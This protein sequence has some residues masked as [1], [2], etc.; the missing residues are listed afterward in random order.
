MLHGKG[1]IAP[2][3]RGMTQAARNGGG[4]PAASAP[5]F[6]KKFPRNPYANF[7]AR[8]PAVSLCVSMLVPLI[9]AIVSLGIYTTLDVSTDRFTAE[10]SRAAITARAVSAAEDYWR[11][12]SS[13]GTAG[14]NGLAAQGVRQ[15]PK[16]HI[17]L[18]FLLSC[19]A[20]DNNA[21]C[22]SFLTPDNLH[23]IRRVE[24]LVKTV[25]GYNTAC[26]TNPFLGG[27]L[28]AAVPSCAPINSVTQYFFATA[29]QQPPF[30]VFD[31]AGELQLP[32]ADTLSR[33]RLNPQAEWYFNRGFRQTQQMTA[34]RSQVVLGWPL[35]GS[36]GR[37]FT[38][39]QYDRY[40]DAIVL[41]IY[42]RVTEFSH[43]R[44]RVTI[45]GDRV[46]QARVAR[47]I[48][49]EFWRAPVSIIIVVAILFIHCRTFVV[50]CLGAVQILLA[51][52]SGLSI[53][54]LS[55]NGH[56]PMLSLIALF[57]TV[58]FGVDGV[59][60]T[61]DTFVH[62]GIF[63]TSGRRNTLTVAQ[64]IA[65]VQRKALRGIAVAHV[66]AI[67]VFAVATMSPVTE[68]H[69]F[70]LFMVTIL[71]CSLY[72][73]ATF[74][75]AGVLF[76]HF[77][78]SK[79][80]RALQK[81]KE[82]LLENGQRARHP[83]MI[84]L[85][86]SMEEQKELTGAPSYADIAEG[87][88]ERFAQ[89]S[90]TDIFTHTHF[91][92]AAAT[93]EWNAR[94][95]VVTEQRQRKRGVLPPKER[96]DPDDN[97]AA[98]DAFADDNAVPEPPA[99]RGADSPTRDDGEFE[100]VPS[101]GRAVVRVETKTYSPVDEPLQ[102]PAHDD[103]IDIA[104]QSP[105]ARAAGATA[106][107][108]A[109]VYTSIR[110]IPHKNIVHVPAAMCFRSP[111]SVDIAQRIIMA[112]LAKKPETNDEEND[113]TSRPEGFANAADDAEE[114]E[115]LPPDGGPPRPTR[116]PKAED[117]LPLLFLPVEDARDLDASESDAHNSRVDFNRRI[118]EF[119]A[120]WDV[121]AADIEVLP[122]DSPMAEIAPLLAHR[123]V[124]CLAGP[125]YPSDSHIARN[126]VNAGLGRVK[127]GFVAD[128]QELDVTRENKKRQQENTR[129]C[130]SC[131]KRWEDRE[132]APRKYCCG[133][134]GSRENEGRAERDAR[135]LSK[136]VKHEG[137]GRMER[138][139]NNTWATG[140]HRGR[141]ALVAVMVIAIVGG[142]V[143]ISYLKPLTSTVQLLRDNTNENEHR[144]ASA[145][146]ATPDEPCDYCG[147]AY[148]TPEYRFHDLTQIQTCAAQGYGQLLSAYVDRCGVC[149]GSD[150]CVDCRGVP[151]GTYTLDQ[152]GVCL[153]PNSADRDHCR[154]CENPTNIDPACTWC[155]VHRNMSGFAGAAC[156]KQCTPATCPPARGRCNR[157]TG[158][159]ECHKDSLRGWFRTV[160]NGT[161]P[162]T[163]CNAC[164][165]GFFPE[166]QGSALLNLSMPCTQE[167]SRSTAV[168]VACGSCDFTGH[169][170][171]SW[172][173]RGS[174]CQARDRALCNHGTP[175]SS[176]TCACDATHGGPACSGDRTCS[177]RG[178][179]YSALVAPELGCAC[180]GA[181][182]G[183][184]CEYCSCRNG[185]TCTATGAC[186]C[187]AG[188]GGDL[189][190]ACDAGCSRGGTCPQPWR[191]DE[192][193][194]GACLVLFCSAADVALG[195]SCPACIRNVTGWCGAHNPP[196]FTDPDLV[197]RQR[198]CENDPVCMWNL[199]EQLC[200]EKYNRTARQL[201][202]AGCGTCRGYWAGP[203]CA[204][205]T[206]TGASCTPAGS[207]QACDG[208]V[209]A[210]GMPFPVIDNCGTCGGR[211]QCIGC[212]GV[213]NSNKVFDV[214]GVCGGDGACRRGE[215]SPIDVDFVFGVLNP[216]S[217]DAPPELPN[218]GGTHIAT[219]W[220]FANPD[221]ARSLKGICRQ[222]R[223]Q[224]TG[225]NTRVRVRSCVV[226]DYALW[227]TDVTNLNPWLANSSGAAV[228]GFPLTLFSDRVRNQVFYHFLQTTNRMSEVGWRTLDQNSSD[229]K[230]AYIKVGTTA[231]A[232]HG[233]VTSQILFLQDRFDALAESITSVTGVSTVH[234]SP[235]WVSAASIQQSESGLIW[236]TCI[237][238][239]VFVSIINIITCSV[240][241]TVIAMLCVGGTMLVS[242]AFFAAF[243]F[244]LGAVEQSGVSL[245]L[246]ISVE[247][248]IHLLHS[249]LDTVHGSQSHLFAVETTRLQSF[250]GAVMRSGS[251]IVA[252]SA[253]GIVVAL[254]HISSDV[255]PIHR[256]AQI[257]II[258]SLSSLVFSLVFAGALLC[259]IGPLVD[260][261]FITIAVTLLLV[262]AAAWGVVVFGLFMGK[263]R[264]PDGEVAIR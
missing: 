159:C 214:C 111:E 14:F 250:R 179:Y 221:T 85:L 166:V 222:F 149:Y 173:Y 232:E 199:T 151:N 215:Q 66:C 128:T 113:D 157:W 19:A 132:V 56:L 50:A 239:F 238:F 196:H 225:A 74:T 55:R 234:T 8:Y 130:G 6:G 171:C 203:N 88:R 12:I 60:V 115:M 218:Y 33:L 98:D 137:Y 205:C 101:G 11:K 21:S 45:D 192:Y 40:V 200:F 82:T 144:D 139:F 219:A 246:G 143:G 242:I 136:R 76:H 38:Q 247:N 41:R 142:C 133:M 248:A 251:A 81:Q 69:D 123:V 94:F 107:P 182:A 172:G 65:Y 2:D 185:G 226:D 131:F 73:F 150:A 213:I 258:V 135:I 102:G 206:A 9:L 35:I 68:L 18:Q 4:D 124:S 262:W 49:D 255:V 235:R 187:R 168:A 22:S 75:P 243:D 72:F 220:D 103:F 112:R 92:T 108:L 240:G 61:Y 48:E 263:A 259:L 211:N 5:V 164:H 257:T 230:V 184:S 245:V 155:G 202:A 1:A 212:D 54:A 197:V 178:T 181:W 3:Q 52:L 57:V 119:H 109:G 193:D 96:A 17:T 237:G 99:R 254:L 46:L 44:V 160:G 260:Y 87:Q 189:C 121:V 186:E 233:G 208:R 120:A 204:T 175:T 36:D 153:P 224:S 158:E 64:R 180:F 140:V 129:F 177:N 231:I 217:T 26:W 201:P 194:W 93:A 249:Y 7:L 31:G 83:Q 58:L 152:C 188:W 125:S 154:L 252:S 16:Y 67:I 114:I 20:A 62:S 163:S 167:C 210:H 34:V 216:H 253:V 229:F 47:A 223:E 118:A 80:R 91:I 146:F 53:F 97:D 156:T 191:A 110:L 84:E 195:R 105:D 264:G 63:A 39:D 13:G 23:A 116:Q 256:A 42:D 190:A 43:P 117:A 162:T 37:E 89:R 104:E 10:S 165:E 25:E 161:A 209:Y 147:G 134:L 95:A 79:R 90:R 122:G 71:C 176:Q 106:E 70:A 27:T 86:R 241:T 15:Q 30:F 29:V 227:L 198:R 236:A 126:F 28:N 169:C 32:L 78:F 170:N 141:W 183:P 100:N 207:A 24:D 244:E 261:R 127:R 148:R 77:Y 138:F 51:Y 145:A 228:G 59:L 174:A